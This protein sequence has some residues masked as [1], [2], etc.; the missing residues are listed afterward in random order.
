MGPKVRAACWFAERTGGFAAIGSIHDTQALLRGEAGTRVALETRR[1]HGL[2]GTRWRPPH[3]S[4]A[5]PT[6]TPTWH[7]LTREGAAQEL[8]VEPERGLTSEEAAER[9]ARYGPNRFAEAKSESRWHAFLRQYQ[10]PMQIVL[11]GAGVISIYPVKQAGHGDRDPA[12]DAAQR[13]A[14]AQPGGQGRGGGRGAGED[15]DRQGA[16]APRR[17]AQRSCRPSSSCPAT[18]SR[19]R[20]A[21]WCPPT[22]ACWPRRR[23]RSPRRR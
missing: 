4:D 17:R 15:D 19:S 6:E 18:S 9:L 20:P 14:R 3:R 8:H 22:G 13:R 16:R 2:R 23:S 11:L 10:D 1:P 5:P 7:V 12:A 21:T